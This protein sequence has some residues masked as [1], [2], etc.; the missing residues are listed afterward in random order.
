MEKQRISSKPN[1]PI[2]S[3]NSE[4]GENKSSNSSNDSCYPSQLGTNSSEFDIQVLVIDHDNESLISTVKMLRMFAYKVTMVDLA[5]E[6]LEIIL[7]GKKHF[8]VVIAN[9]DSD[10]D[11]FKFCQQVAKQ[12]IL[13]LL[14]CSNQ[15][16]HLATKAIENGAILVIHKPVDEQIIGNYLWQ[17]V[18]RERLLRSKGK[19]KGKNSPKST[20]IIAGKEKNVSR[21]PTM[22]VGEGKTKRKASKKKRKE[23]EKVMMRKNV[24]IE[25]TKELHSKFMDA[26]QQLGEG[27]CFPKQ[28]TEIMNVPGLTRSQVASHLQKCRHGNWGAPYQRKCHGREKMRGFGST[29]HGEDNNLAEDQ[30]SST[31]STSGSTNTAN[32]GFFAKVTY[33]F[34]PSN[35]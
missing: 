8:D 11:G 5:S 19:G 2:V 14:T 29:C 24:C 25:W 18:M 22:E 1:Y 35:P 10:I 26:V 4:N 23:P 3:G 20:V 15:E 12:G 9:V 16:K 28:I 31:N 30:Q 27:R 21:G 17:I 7:S 33:D 34:F 13:V 32:N 6:A